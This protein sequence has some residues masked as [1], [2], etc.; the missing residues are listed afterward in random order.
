MTAFEALLKLLK[1][2]LNAGGKSKEEIKKELSAFVEDI[3]ESE[4]AGIVEAAKRN[5][6]ACLLYDLVALIENVPEPSRKEIEKYS[7][8]IVQNSYR[9][10]NVD[11]GLDRTL[12]KAG[13]P[14][15]IMKGIA[16]A[17]DFSVPELRKSGDVDI[18]L[19]NPKDI[20]RAVVEIEKLGFKPEEEQHSLHHVSMSDATGLEI[21]VHTMLA[22]PFDNNRIN[23][24]V[25]KLV[26]ECGRQTI[27]KTIMGAELPVL[28]DAYHAYELLLHM[29]QHFLRAGFG[30]KLLCDWVVLWNRGLN[31]E[32]GNT[33]LRLVNESGIKGFS[34]MI[35]RTCIK[36]LG[37]ERKNVLWMKPFD[38][39]RTREEL[40]KETEIFMEELMDAEEFGKAKNRM[41]ALRGN[42]F[43]DYVREFHHQMHL[44][45][46]KAGKVFVLWPVLWTITLIRF[47]RNNKKVRS[48]SS[49][50]LFESAG[51][52]G[53]LVK[54]M[55][56]FQ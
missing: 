6:V 1:V 51:K 13:I 10:L 20:D 43:F 14:F 16:A 7:R 30:V 27:R 5:S 46:P 21:E 42:G 32:D 3:N 38:N 36:Y 34:D 53:K 41:V 52:R 19:T 44:N 23:E 12:K 33:Y 35:T 39:G 11:M 24:Y 15:V 4:W 9:L 8:R 50:E 2:S 25:D 28:Q 29:L 45:F 47:L 54:G 49:K 31:E 55:K 22:E 17:A 56:L 37:M 18:L 40:E 48:V 26:P